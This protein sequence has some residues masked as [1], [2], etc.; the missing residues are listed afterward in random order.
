MLKKFSVL[1]LLLCL[2]AGLASAS[3][4]YRIRFN[5]YPEKIRAVFDFFGEFTYE[6][7][8]ASK[9]QI[10]LRLKNSA[11]SPAIQNYVEVNDLI[12]RY[13]QVERED[14][15]LKITIP[16]AAPVEYNV[17]Y[18]SDP[19][20]LVIDFGR[21][22]LNIVSGST[23]EDGIELLKIQKGTPSGNILAYALKVDPNKV[24]I[25]PAL[26]QKQ[27]SGF[28]E[29]FINFFNPWK[30][31]EEEKHF[32]LDKVGNIVR[33]NGGV[34]GINGTYF[35]YNGKPLGALIINQELVSFPLYDRTALFFDANRQPYID[36]LYL[37]SYC[38]LPNGVRLDITGIN[39]KRGA[40]SVILYSPAWGETTGTNRE[41]IEFVV[42]KSTVTE[43][44]NGN[45]KIP[46]DGYVI[47]FSGSPVE[48]LGQILKPGDKI[49]TKISFVPYATSPRSILHL[50]SG[51]PRLLKN[52]Q[53]YISKYGEKF[54]AD[55]AKGRAART[56]V[57]IT[58]EGKLLLLIVEGARRKSQSADNQP[59]SI[60]ATLE[61]LAALLLNLG[62]TE[63]L[64]LDGGSSSTM[65][66]KDRVINS[67]NSGAQ[68]AVSNALVLRPR[69][70]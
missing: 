58:A 6:T 8:T 30:K 50:I 46:E 14:Q 33:D 65:I 32:F 11:A 20:R 12:V 45:A 57:G 36:N 59:G 56:A 9:N 5:S 24:E 35:A 37:N 28:F 34:A 13:F 43:V 19:P 7:A 26:A 68:R 61:E 54:R 62:A 55:I 47:S 51:G 67:L 63:A 18:L 10:V 53:P 3:T 4:L 60:G 17:F 42:I 48:T 15:D 38:R 2:L 25:E 16:L 27:K 44:S 49:E 64:N 23:V 1:I 21:D 39:E 22:Y 41:G 52:G 40:E 29:S 70:N 31:P 66:V 69:L